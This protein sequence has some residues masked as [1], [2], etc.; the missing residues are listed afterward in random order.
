MKIAV[1]C[2]SNKVAEHFGHCEQFN[3]YEVDGNKII[4]KEIIKN[5]GHKTGFL[6]RFLNDLGVN[7]IISG[8]MGSGAIDIFNE[9]KI[10]VITGNLG[11]SDEI[12]N[13]YLLGELKNSGEI[14]NKHQYKNECGNH[15][16]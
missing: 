14:C 8:G 15:Y 13:K 7:V 16:Q 5:P 2:F 11:N 3:I 12:V 10:E 6:P 9:E 1:A 4:S